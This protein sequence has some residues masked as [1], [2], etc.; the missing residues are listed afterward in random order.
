MQKSVA[1]GALA[2]LLIGFIAPIVSASYSYPSADNPIDYRQ[3]INSVS[4]KNIQQH[5]ANLSSV[6]SRVTGYPGSQVAADYITKVFQSYENLRVEVQEYEVVVPLDHG[7][8]IEVLYPENRT[9][10]AHALWPNYVQTSPTPPEGIKGNLVYA[11]TG[12][13]EELNGKVIRNNIVLMEFNS[14]NNWLNAA[15]F[16]ARAVIF[17]APS[18]TNYHESRSKFLLV[19]VHFP[20]LY[21]SQQDG[22]YLRGLLAQKGEVLVNIKSSMRFESVKARN[23]IGIV[24]GTVHP[25]EIII[26]GAHYDTWSVVPALA[27]GADEATSVAS[28]LELARF[29]S[30]N[31][32]DRTMW[33]VALSGHWEALAGAREFVDHFGFSEKVQSDEQKILLFM[34]LDF[35]TDEKRLATLYRGSF[36]DYG[37]LERVA[38]LTPARTHIFQDYLPAMDSQLGE[39][40]ST[41]VED[42]FREAGYWTSVPIPYM[43][44][45]EPLTMSGGV[46]FT[47]RTTNSYRIG[48]GS[49]IND[50]D[51]VN[52]EN[53]RPQV[54]IAAGLARSFANEPKMLIDWASVKPSRVLVLRGGWHG[55]LAGFITL[56]GKAVIFNPVK[57]WYDHVPNALT[58]TLRAPGSNFP[59]LNI[60]TFA[61]ATGDFVIH[62]LGL[63][64]ALLY[65][66]YG[67]RA[68][69]YSTEGFVFNSTTG[70]ITHAPDLGQYGARSVSFFSPTDQYPSYST[71]VLFKSST[72]VVYDLIDINRM[73]AVVS[74]DPRFRDRVWSGTSTPF[75]LLIYEF[76]TLSEYINWGTLYSPSESIGV[77][78]VPP[79]TRFIISFRTGEVGQ[80]ASFIVNASENLPEGIGFY[81]AKGKELHIAPSSRIFSD[82]LFYVANHRY[83]ILF[84]SYVRS[85]T[86]EMAFSK[87]ITDLLAAQRALEHLQ[88]DDAY[89]ASL[90]AWTWQ[91]LAYAETMRLINDASATSTFFFTML[92]LFAYFF[93]R[94]LFSARGFKRLGTMIT[95]VG[96]CLVVFYNLHPSM[97]MQA[98]ISIG[99]LGLITLFFF[100]LAFAVFVNEAIGIARIA[101]VKLLGPTYHKTGLIDTLMLAFPL[102]TENMRKRRGR[103]AM[104]MATVI[105]ITFSLI[106]LT[107]TQFYVS[108]KIGG[109]PGK[110]PYNGLLLKKGMTQ[111]R[112]F[113]GMGII[114]YSRGVVG[115]G[116]IVSPRVWYYPQSIRSEIVRADLQSS[117][118][119]YS[120]FA[121]V[122]LSAEEADIN[123]TFMTALEGR[124][125]T[126][127]DYQACVITSA[128]S[129]ALGTK[130]GDK[131]N[132]GGITLTVIGIADASVL[133]ALVDLDQL[134]MTPLDPNGMRDVVLAQLPEEYFTQLAWEAVIIV[135]YRLA[136]DL[137]GSLASVAIQIPDIEKINEVAQE[138]AT[139]VD[140]GVYAARDGRIMRYARIAALAAGGWESMMFPLFIGGMTIFSTM[141]GAIKERE[142]EISIHSL[143]GSPPSTI[144]VLFLAESAVY[145]SV[146]SVI[147]YLLG[148]I[149]NGTLVALNLL[150][151]DFIL[152]F[153]SVAVAIT[154]GICISFVLLST[155]YPGL[156]ASRL[157]TPSLERRWK[158]PTKPKGEEW[159]IPTPFVLFDV[160]EVYGVLAFMKRYAEAFALEA[161]ALFAVREV[162][163]S[164][165]D[166]ALTLIV[167]L[168]PYE[169]SVTQRVKIFAHEIENR[170]TFIIHL[171]RLT[172]EIG[173][174]IRSNHYFL[175]ALRKQLLTWRGLS[176][177]EKEEYIKPS[178]LPP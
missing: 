119:S 176:S 79:E 50:L 47:V 106:A 81:A 178:P 105:I 126:G 143:V 169:A 139:A 84:E 7:S 170:Y 135:P 9:L 46:G 107:S 97:R 152:N 61:N 18:D 57:N 136:L 91:R 87:G 19:P 21:V 108:V 121:V 150:P 40:F 43:L 124:W 64:P 72:V 140:V 59:F 90:A 13:L 68:M 22:A 66:T 56:V 145:A 70:L 28:L 159:E 33:F 96:V 45:S 32:P 118:G 63:G 138:I 100:V 3:I 16:G 129:Q 52:F 142:K 77:L 26:V 171:A 166:K 133:N 98:N 27:P 89:Y 30:E 141:L 85:K 158:I 58:V 146:G 113:L 93:E 75:R 177:R 86:A 160:R 24:E 15:K 67:A 35:S 102:A 151:P 128:A 65:A 34:G 131:I 62:G 148:L 38:R 115:P 23:I 39:S 127:D 92:I 153:S 5:V 54:W 116:A 88:Y 104:V 120:V 174:W 122:G 172:G 82:N 112:D 20:R 101:R 41:I 175:D 109:A 48:W 125:F 37:G 167:A 6:G 114:L 162:G 111:P 55:D 83:N 94:L 155:L 137:G 36:Y 25:D 165:P 49:P 156:K 78:F 132:L 144:T 80:S 147:G 71:T 8:S 103:T 42:G 117:S 2:I 4:F 149:V 11:G 51:F 130:V 157:V 163:I 1:K 31:K 12:E 14:G 10:M 60:F 99:Y 173:V 134:P 161:G 69:G 123:P 154:M 73:Q 164:Y 168:A 110:A 44:D 29:N 74:F 95:I 76:M 53:L 17:V